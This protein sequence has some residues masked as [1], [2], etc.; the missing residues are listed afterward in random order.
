MSLPFDRMPDPNL[1]S[2]QHTAFIMDDEEIIGA[3]AGSHL[4]AGE[5]VPSSYA[6][7]PCRSSVR[8]QGVTSSHPVAKLLL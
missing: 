8:M 7:F 4:L 1:E 3:G 5:Q 2:I 6:P